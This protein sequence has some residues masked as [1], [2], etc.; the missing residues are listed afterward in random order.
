MKIGIFASRI[1]AAGEGRRHAF[2]NAIARLYEW[3]IRIA[4]GG[5]TAVRY[6][7][8]SVVEE[9]FRRV[10]GVLVDIA[11]GDA[12]SILLLSPNQRQYAQFRRRFPGAEI[13]C[14][15]RLSW[16]LSRK[17]KWWF[18]LIFAGNVFMYS[19]NPPVWF[20]NILTC[21]RRLL[22]QDVINRRRSTVPPYLGLDHDSM[23][24]QFRQRGVVSEFPHAFDLENVPA[25]CEDFTPYDSRDG[26]L[27]FIARFR[28]AAGPRDQGPKHSRFGL[29]VSTFWFHVSRGGLGRE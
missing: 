7:A 9:D 14:A 27:H 12:Q 18:D 3:V 13:L 19:P 17:Q 16:D 2:L 6:V 5:W 21:G 11:D 8:V 28:N 22:V 10:E 15:D 1:I 24:F 26:A 25:I 20:E 29:Q 4:N 23:R